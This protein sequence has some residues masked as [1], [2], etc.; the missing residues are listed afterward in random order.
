M[1]PLRALFALL[2]L[3]PLVA[4][5][6]HVPTADAGGV[7]QDTG[8]CD[9]VWFGTDLS[10]CHWH[11]LSVG[12]DPGTGFSQAIAEPG[13]TEVPVFVEL[14]PARW[15]SFQLGTAPGV[16]NW[17]VPLSVAARLHMCGDGGCGWFLGGYWEPWRKSEATRR[18]VLGATLGYRFQAHFNWSGGPVLK[19]WWGPHLFATP[20]L[21]VDLIGREKD[22]TPVP[23]AARLAFEL[24]W[25][26]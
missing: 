21:S 6:V 13:V 16:P 14:F 3:A 11:I 24:G 7:I 12:V 18:F 15:V 19:D 4:C 2:L 1:R 25:S 10:D 5:G 22:G 9:P 20:A 8:R 17:P 23:V 26:F